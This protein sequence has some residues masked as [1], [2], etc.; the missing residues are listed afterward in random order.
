M[1]N[2][3]VQFI[4]MYDYVRDVWIQEFYWFPGFRRKLDP[5]LLPADAGSFDMTNEEQS[6]YM[7][8]RQLRSC[9]LQTS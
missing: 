4:R 9:R 2:E 6:T 3:V 1:V 8:L 5:A 7:I